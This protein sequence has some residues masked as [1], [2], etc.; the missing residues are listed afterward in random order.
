MSLFKKLHFIFIWITLFL[1]FFIAGFNF[2][3]FTDGSHS[4]YASEI[5]CSGPSRELN[6]SPSFQ[7]SVQL[8][9]GYDYEPTQLPDY[10]TRYVSSS[11][12]NFLNIFIESTDSLRRVILKTYV[13]KSLI[14]AY[15]V[16][17]SLLLVKKFKCLGEI[18]TKLL[19]VTFSF[20]YLFFGASGVYPAPIAALAVIPIFSILKIMNCEKLI[21]PKIATA[22]YINFGIS[23]SLIIS[24]RFETSAFVLLGV[25]MWS[26]YTFSKERKN[27]TFIILA[28]STACFAIA[29]NLNQTFRQSFLESA[30]GQFKVLSQVQANNSFLVNSIGNSGLSL[31][32]PLTFVDNSTRNLN[33]LIFSD[34]TNVVS[35]VL[36]FII[37]WIPIFLLTTRALKTIFYPMFNRK[38][39]M[40]RVI[41]ERIPSL[42][43]MIVFFLVPMYARTVWFFWYLVPLLVIF[44]FFVDYLKGVERNYKS[45]IFISIV[46]NAVYFVLVVRNLGAIY[47]LGVW[48]DPLV[49]IFFGLSLGL[50]A[51][52]LVKSYVLID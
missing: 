50:I 14:A 5:V 26:I 6:C 20:P 25:F 52:K 28:V 13:I 38:S 19:L 42:F 21:P 23:M 34:N 15:L 45:L 7:A 33:D 41:I 49:Q 44:I 22:L 3:P 48:I 30:T 46:A 17:F 43:L 39:L 51:F 11:F 1:I 29:Y 24:N 36:F 47:L 16:T 32:S 18:T 4:S 10:G 9:R 2:I 8:F 31:I 12:A 37:S 35:K 40:L 27:R